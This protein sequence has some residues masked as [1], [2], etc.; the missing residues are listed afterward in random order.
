[1]FRG[2]SSAGGDELRAGARA[3]LMATD[4][5]RRKVLD[6]Q[7]AGGREEL[8]V[9][10]VAE[11]WLQGAPGG[12]IAFGGETAQ[13]AIGALVEGWVATLA[14]TLAREPL[15]F[16]ELRHRI[17]GIRKRQLKRR[18]DAMRAAGL[19]EAR[20]E[21]GAGAIYSVTDWLRA[22]IAPLVAAT[23]C[24]RREP[25]PAAAP[26]DALDVE[27][28]FLLCLPLLQLPKELSGSCSLGV[29]LADDGSEALA[30]VTAQI[31]AGRVVSC[32]PDLGAP[33]D[34]WAAAGAGDWL[35]TL[36]APDAR[37]VETGGDDRLAE[38]LLDRLH[39]LLFGLPVV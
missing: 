32:R 4:P 15:T 14:H 34:A 2:E 22:G 7:T 5:A 19:V 27:A 39:G 37:Q 16:P 33:T 38:I 10:F 1:V 18:L 28:A 20:P 31:D 24:E 36:I 13:R 29:D 8:F 11:R 26:I 35:D 23:R 6:E 21:G 17:G 3:L 30:G 12:P 25:R 9:A